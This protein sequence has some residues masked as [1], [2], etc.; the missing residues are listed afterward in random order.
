MAARKH[1]RWIQVSSLW[2]YRVLT[3]CVLAIGLAFAAAVLTLR[4]WILPNIE[5]YREDIARIVSETA[6]QK[7]EIGY[8]RA[9]WEG[10]RP[11]LVLEQV[12]VLDA[13]GRPALE[14]SRVDNTLSWLSL[15]TL[16]LRFHSF[17][18]HR[19]KLEIRR[20]AAGA[21]SI[22]GIGVSGQGDGSGFA[23]WLLQQRDIEVI[24]AS[25]AWT[26]EQRGAPRL[27][28]KHV[29]L[30]LIN[31]G[32]RHRFGLHALPPAELAAP[33]DVRGDLT[34]DRIEALAEWNGKI[35]LELDY[36]DIAAWRQWVPFPVPFP[37]GQGAV[38]AWLTFSKHSLAGAT[39]DVRLANVQTR[40]AADLP[41]LDLSEL[42]GRIGWKS[43]AAG[44]EV[45]TAKLGL[46]T[47]G[48]L[49]LH[50][51]DF[52][53][54]VVAGT[55]R[56]P[57]RGELEVD[58]LE[59]EPL[60]TLADR[61]PLAQ[62]ARD[63]LARF[64]PQGGLRD[65]AVRWRGDWQKP[66]E[67][68]FKG[69]FE[70]LA[71]SPVGKMPGFRGAS[72]S[73]D[74]RESG[75]TLYLNTQKAAVEMPLLFRDPLEF[76][77]LTAQLRWERLA[78]QTEVRLNSI[79]FSNSHLAG[80]LFGNFRTGE[81]T[82]GHIDLTG[83]LARADLRQV[84]RYVP[85]VVGADEREWLDYAF[86]AG[87]VT[88][89]SLRI[90]GDVD[91]IPFADGQ[92]G[93]FQATARV[94]GGALQYAKGWPVIEN[95]AAEV[96]FRGQRM[97]I[98][99]RQA[100]VFGTR[101]SKVHA[102]IPDLTA[103]EEVLNITG[104]AAGP[105]N[106]FL[107]FIEKSPVL[108]AIDRFTEGWKAKGDGRLGLK[109]DI[110]MRAKHKM[111]IAGAFHFDGNT[112]ATQPAVPA[113]EQAGGRV[114]F[115]DS[116]V[117]VK[118]IKGTVLGGPVTI[119]ANTRGDATAIITARG[120]IDTDKLRDPSAQPAWLQHVRGS[121]DWRT[122]ITTR[123]READ[124][125][126]ESDLKG[127]AVY[128]PPPLLKPAG[129]VLPVRIERRV[130]NSTQDRIGVQVGDIVG[131]GLVR[132]MDGAAVSIPRGVVRFGG[133]ATEP[134]RAGVWVSGTV[135]SLDLDRWLALLRQP[136]EPMHVDWGGID[137]K[138]GTL[139]ALGRRYSDLAIYAVTQ[140]DGNW[141]S[142]LVGKE[143]EGTLLWQPQG[144]G[145]L[146]ARMKTLTIPASSPAT[147]QAPASAAGERRQIDLPALDITAEQ[148]SLGGKVLGSLQVAAT[149]Q[150][151]GWR[152]EQLSIVNPESK[153]T[154][155]GLWE[156]WLTAP[157]TRVNIRLEAQ[158]AG[159]L[160]ER[161]GY[162]EGLKRG[163]AKI[164]GAL[165]WQ[166]TPYEIDY[167]SLAG[168]LVLDA[169]KGQFD[170]IDAGVGKLLG[171]M[172]LQALPRRVSLDF[173]DV[174][175]DGFAFDEIVGPVKIDQGI[176]LTDNFRIQGPSARVLM[177]G[178]VDLARETQDLRVRVT[179]YL[180][181]SVSIAGALIG[182]PVAGIATF[183]AQKM[184]K[185]P[186]DQMAAFEYD[187]TGTWKEPQVAK[188]Q[189]QPQASAVE[190][191]P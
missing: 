164:E 67:Y 133:R 61:L 7:I 103:K 63:Q 121:T 104:E 68:S 33:I 157:R 134:D 89:G 28:F 141:R 154:L 12:R 57:A 190:A 39:V 118:G 156:G 19:P 126:L 145:R 187:V 177:K 175:S 188:V 170:K 113:V 148:F 16:Q 97:D 112:V 111:K 83:N 178:K 51:T 84:G 117:Q 167:P 3:W 41:E 1:V 76:D 116:S 14:F 62:E 101:L 162:S 56:A 71:L 27:E 159:K 38:R 8:I 142:S 105:T 45:T 24:D 29:N 81:S 174:F 22:A 73:V 43:S 82:G 50:P 179:P 59:L 10:L 147:L 85:V 172:S 34:G 137:L 23:D 136:G 153:F 168:N 92:S 146:T 110:P 46:T 66:S 72:G 184:L 69:R 181:E 93:V 131:M 37:R 152:I 149:P 144:R 5:Q 55:K 99:G 15:A 36:A 138:L 100:N 4:Y 108:D 119:T 77:V 150:G 90:K 54:H 115:T 158:D 185:D 98:Y 30:H 171:V 191:G 25:I 129:Q 107:A 91:A 124:I 40:L 88:A 189:R 9:N 32:T 44:F 130:V 109:L 42:S 125:V 75:G 31:R 78:G 87:D 65:V 173:R 86:R 143:F 169:A 122:V 102:A 80:T 60:V 47:T 155:E 20:D 128:L 161:L 70:K 2:I 95:I 18:I 21:I 183:L 79:A 140:P 17:D 163:T 182:G 11:H 106:E 26:D 64:S 180:S 139:D 160:L 74:A 186:I 165:T 58:T 166:G 53:L 114:E 132:E 127:L 135:G 49:T 151:A 52:R 6:K 176:A 94:S 96:V 48:G 13:Q 123:K 120:R 35:Y